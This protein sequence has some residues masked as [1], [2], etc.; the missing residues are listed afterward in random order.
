MVLL[1]IAHTAI[2]TADKYPSSQ[3]CSGINSNMM[4]IL[5]FMIVVLDGIDCLAPERIPVIYT[6][7]VLIIRNYWR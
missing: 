5:V 4:L 3:R 2:N 7:H 6:C 1:T